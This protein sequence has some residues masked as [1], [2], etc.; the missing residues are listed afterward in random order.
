MDISTKH[1][2]PRM[3]LVFIN[4][5]LFTASETQSVSLRGVQLNEI[6][7]RRNIFHLCI[8]KLLA[9]LPH[10]E[11][12]PFYQT[13]HYQKF[14]ARGS[15]HTMTVNLLPTSRNLTKIDT[16]HLNRVLSL[17]KTI[18]FYAHYNLRTTPW[19]L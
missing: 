3:P 13:F 4:T 12:R 16:A 14:I 5:F 10:R 8:G 11:I 1:C 17:K 18:N 2:F 6:V 7:V 19:S 9:Q 15:L